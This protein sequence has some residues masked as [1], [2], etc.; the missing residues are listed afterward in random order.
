MQKVYMDLILAYAIVKLFFYVLR[1]D[2]VMYV[3]FLK[4][5]RLKQKASF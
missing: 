1:S 3:A 2:N 4:D 5:N